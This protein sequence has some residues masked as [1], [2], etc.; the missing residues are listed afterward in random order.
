MNYYTIGKWKIQYDRATTLKLYKEIRPSLIWQCNC[1]SC[2][3]YNFIREKI[4]PGNFLEILDKLGINYKKEAEIYHIRKTGFK[5]QL[6]CGWYHFTGRFIKNPGRNSVIYLSD[7]FQIF[8][9]ENK[10]LVHDVFNTHPVIQVE[11]K[12]I[13]PINA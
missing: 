8:F 12:T 9:T 13:L 5:K 10:I 4:Y 3:N 6:Y 1:Y 7:N 11:F 2:R